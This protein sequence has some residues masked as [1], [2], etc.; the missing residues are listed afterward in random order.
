MAEWLKDN[1]DDPNLIPFDIRSPREYNHAH[2]PRARLIPYEKILSFHENSS[3]FDLAPKE[4][5]EELLCN[6]GITDD[7]N[8]VIYG[9][10]GGATATR[11]FWSLKY[12]GLNVK[13]LDISFSKW[14]ELGYPVSNSI[15]T[16]EPTDFVLTKP[17]INF[18]VDHEYILSK[19]DDKNLI[20][21]DTRSPDEFTGVIAAGPK[22]G[23]I[24]NSKNFPW[25]M[26]IGDDGYIFK[27]TNDLTQIFEKHGITKDREIICYCQVGERASH[28][29]VALKLCD[30]PNVKIYDR[31]FADWSNRDNLP[32][33]V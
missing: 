15:E 7:S 29:F 17:I 10:R 2:L 21:L 3:Y 12:Y 24:P 22:A 19:L 26:A 33:E 13:F 32:I 14:M 6:S 23:R 31:S 18:K 16:I 5:I 20:L 25:E 4:Q 9:D 1:L 11:L 28:T 8:I 27:K 30:Y